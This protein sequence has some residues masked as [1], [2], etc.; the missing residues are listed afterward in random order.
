MCIYIYTYIVY[1]VGLDN[2]LY[3]MHCSYTK[4]F[5]KFLFVLWRHCLHFS[6]FQNRII[7]KETIWLELKYASKKLIFL[8]HLPTLLHFIIPLNEILELLLRHELN[9]YTIKVN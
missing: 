5:L 1:L 9:H 3:K 7:C 8:L 6:F 2:K 4:N